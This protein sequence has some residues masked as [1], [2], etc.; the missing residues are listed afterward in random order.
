MSESVWT[1]VIPAARPP[2]WQGQLFALFVVA[3][4]FAF[5]WALT[6]LIGPEQSPFLTFTPAVLVATA[7]AGR[8]AGL[9][10]LTLGGVAGHWAFLPP[11]F[12]FGSGK[13]VLWGVA[14]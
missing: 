10:A 9:T 7:L 1:R 8:W 4:A 11:Y 2:L 6:P 13:T 3:V 14:A 5:R 12:G